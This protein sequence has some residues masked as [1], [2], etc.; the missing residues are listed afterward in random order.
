MKHDL[1]MR[2]Y[3]T[4]K[5]PADFKLLSLNIRKETG[6][7]VSESTLQRIWGYSTS[8]TRPRLSTLTTLARCLGFIDWDAYVQSVLRES[9]AESNFLNKGLLYTSTMRPSDQ[10]RIA[11]MPDR[12]ATLVYLG[13]LRF[14]VVETLNSKLRPDD[15]ALIRFFRKGSALTCMDVCRADEPLGNYIA[16]EKNGLTELIYQPV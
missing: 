8:R 5:T 14:R 15:T 10:V 7:V 2:F 11:W 12:S 16:G 1:E 6:D 9:H 13:D 3:R 4:F